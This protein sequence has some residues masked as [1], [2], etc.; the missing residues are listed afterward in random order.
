MDPPATLVLVILPKSQQDPPKD[1]MSSKSEVFLIKSLCEYSVP[2]SCEMAERWSLFLGPSCEM[3]ERWSL[4]LG[5][6]CEMV[7]R[8]SLLGPSSSS[9]L[10]RLATKIIVK[11]K[12]KT[13][14]ATTTATVM[15]R[16]DDG[17]TLEF[18]CRCFSS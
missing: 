8:R 12:A 2:S 15:N 16:S 18:G 11:T 14:P 7:E 5:P 13:R 6:S 17:D 1:D 9:L 3:A 4:F 10:S